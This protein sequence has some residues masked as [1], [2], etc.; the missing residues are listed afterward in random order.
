MTPSEDFLNS[1]DKRVR[2]LELVIQELAEKK[3]RSAQLQV[4]T[5]VWHLQKEVD[6]VFQEL[7]EYARCM[8]RS[9]K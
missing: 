5:V 4:E 9:Y 6:D 2:A 8:L 7:E 1:E 3:N